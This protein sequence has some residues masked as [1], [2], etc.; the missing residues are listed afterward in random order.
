[1]FFGDVRCSPPREPD[2]P[3]SRQVCRLLG[4]GKK[5]LPEKNTMFLT[6]TILGRNISFY[7]FITYL[8]LMS[9][10]VQVHVCACLSTCVEFRGKL[11]GMSSYHLLCF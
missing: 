9:V 11:S 2:C 5:W 3:A 8:S 10:C 4:L 7:I 1:M 6:G